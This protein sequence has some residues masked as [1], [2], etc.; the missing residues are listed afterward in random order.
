MRIYIYKMQKT[1]TYRLEK[2]Y[3]AGPDPHFLWQVF[4]P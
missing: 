4:A 2:K 1:L 3:G